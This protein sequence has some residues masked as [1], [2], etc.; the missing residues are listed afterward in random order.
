VLTWALDQA[1]STDEVV[2]LSV[3][4]LTLLGGLENPFGN[5]H[6]AQVDATAH[7]NSLI[8]QVSRDRWENHRSAVPVR[9]DVR[10]G[11]PVTELV[12]ASESADM[13]VLGNSHH[14]GLGELGSVARAVVRG[15]AC[16]VAMV[17][18]ADVEAIPAAT[19]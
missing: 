4:N 10:H 9:V 15:A 7:V 3:W 2:A 6:T 11:D 8:E 17:P 12:K 5:L 13:L 14:S 18:I 19:S 1:D 16:A